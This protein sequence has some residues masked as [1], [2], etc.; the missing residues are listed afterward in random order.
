MWVILVHA[1]RFELGPLPAIDLRCGI[2]EVVVELTLSK[3]AP[4]GDCLSRAYRTRLVSSANQRRQFCP[5]ISGPGTKAKEQRFTPVASAIVAAIA[6]AFLRRTSKMAWWLPLS[7]MTA[8]IQVWAGKTRYYRNWSWSRP[9]YRGDRAPEGWS[10]TNTYTILTAFFIHSRWR[11][12]Q[13]EAR[14]NTLGYPGTRP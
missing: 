1:W 14:A 9:T 7:R 13:G 10:S 4:F 3:R 11:S 5:K 8:S 2:A 6:S 12:I